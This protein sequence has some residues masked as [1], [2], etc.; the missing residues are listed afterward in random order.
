MFK[1]TFS[2]NILVGLSCCVCVASLSISAASAEFLKGTASETDMLQKGPSGLSREDL[3]R[4]SDPFGKGNSDQSKQQ[5]FDPSA[6]A[7]DFGG[8][9]PPPPKKP[10]SGNAQDSGGGQFANGVP[11]MASFQN[12]IPQQPMQAPQ[13]PV[14]QG[15]ARQADPNEEPELKLQWDAWHKNVALTI[16][17]RFSTLSNRFFAHGQPLRAIV[18][19]SVTKDGRIV[20]A[21]LTEKSPN[22]IYNTMVITVVNSIN[23]D[24]GV[25]TFP[26]GSRRFS[27]EKSGD[28]TV[29]WSQ[30]EGF[31]STIGDNETVKQQQQ[32]QQQQQQF[33]QQQRR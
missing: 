3:N 11:Q 27:V 20:N 9:A 24:V 29:N 1:T 8:Q 16:Y 32:Q 31:R 25:L 33:Q 2:K 21:H 17:Q 30:N 14:Q 18:A 13:Q 22:I 6:S 7:F 12:G 19:Y 5:F 15:N 23:G 28:F 4:N 10:L 26:Q